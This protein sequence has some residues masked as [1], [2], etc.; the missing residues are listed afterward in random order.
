MEL[1]VSFRSSE[2]AA[3]RASGAI[4]ARHV[5]VVVV[6]LLG[7]LA[8]HLSALGSEQK[9]RDRNWTVP[10]NGFIIVPKWN[11]AFYP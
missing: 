11:L 1:Y 3:M 4:H 2:R 7:G 10:N 9:K 6:L 5:V 8:A